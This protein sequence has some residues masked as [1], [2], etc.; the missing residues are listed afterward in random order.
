MSTHSSIHSSPSK[1]YTIT[2]GGTSNNPNVVEGKAFF[3]KAKLELP[4]EAF[5]SFLNCIKKFNAKQATRDETLK[6][7]KAI[8]GT[9]YE[10]LYTSF[11]R[12][13]DKH[14]DSFN[15]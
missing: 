14:G 4:H 13:L 2:P 9:S 15:N 12:I 10:D 3:R 1:T 5:V 8:F 11:E 6:A 7:V